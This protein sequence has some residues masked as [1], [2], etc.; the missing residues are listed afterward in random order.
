MRARILVTGANGFVGRQLCLDLAG[1]GYIVRAA[2]RRAQ[3]APPGV[4]EQVVVGDIGAA[5]SWN[6][7]LRDIDHVIHTAARVHVMKGS[8]DDED[9]YNSTN[10][11]GTRALANAALRTGVSRFLFLST[12]KVNGEGVADHAYS[13]SDAPQPRDAYGQS[14][15]RAEQYL[16]ETCAGSALQYS[17][18]RPPLV[19]G[20]GVK[21]N[22]R[23]LLGWVD[24]EYPL[25]FGSIRNARSMVNVWNLTD[26][27][28]CLLET[29]A[30]T[31]RVW[32]VADGEDL[33]T[34][35]LVA[36]LAKA[37]NRRSRVFSVPQT[38]LKA[39]AQ[40][41]GRSAEFSRLCGSLRVDA[42][43]TRRALG[44]RPPVDVDTGLRRTV[45]WYEA[46]R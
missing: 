27:L 1:R 30:A 45:E 10:A 20:P 17:I 11:E 39:G 14:K 26:L 33:S 19:Y 32:M 44:W 7:A 40:L 35:L 38:L 37:M 21:A 12:I 28:M 8:N 31:N 25:P 23:R 36:R 5:T 22:F 46:N 4:V 43:D 9:L 18:V 2:V 24:K 3:P 29:A 34:P 41:V 15:L 13:A 6:A 16:A 42:S